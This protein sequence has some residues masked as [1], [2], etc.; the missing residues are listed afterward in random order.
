[1]AMKI[2]RLYET[3]LKTTKSCMVSA[4]FKRILI[5]LLAISV[6]SMIAMDRVPIYYLEQDI[7]EAGIRHDDLLRRERTIEATPEIIHPDCNCA[8]NFSRPSSQIP[9]DADLTCSRVGTVFPILFP[10]IFFLFYSFQ[11][12][13]ATT[14]RLCPSLT[15]KENMK[16]SELPQH[17]LYI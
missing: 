6:I 11:V 3:F 4:R 14:K 12:F 13:G 16:T 10:Y 8:V 9:S 2:T 1:M 7:V 5:V 17:G 15:T